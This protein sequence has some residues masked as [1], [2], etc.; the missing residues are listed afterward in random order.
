MGIE[1]TN[2]IGVK[3]EKKKNSMKMAMVDNSDRL[4][5]NVGEASVVKFLLQDNRINVKVATE[6]ILETK[7][8]KFKEFTSILKHGLMDALLHKCITVKSL[9]NADKSRFNKCHW[10]F[11]IGR[12]IMRLVLII[13]RNNIIYSKIK[14]YTEMM[15]TIKVNHSGKSIYTISQRN[16]W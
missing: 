7:K 12:K 3:D 11:I 2:M 10:S 1:S 6:T 9:T 4:R 16:C 8:E 5:D 15:L 13:L 14:E